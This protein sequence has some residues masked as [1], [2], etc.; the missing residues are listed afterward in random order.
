MQ[1]VLVLL[2]IG[3]TLP[4]LIQPNMEDKGILVALDAAWPLSMLWL[5]VHGVTI[6]RARRWKASRRWAPLVASL[7]FPVAILA[8][9]TGE[10]PGLVVS[11]LWLLVTY[12]TLGVLLMRTTA[13]ELSAIEAP[14]RTGS[15]RNKA[16]AMPGMQP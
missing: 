16:A 15:P 10:W 3:W 4:H 12:V 8:S 7:W 5:I 11:S 9:G 14:A 6:A 2:A 13:C 1:T